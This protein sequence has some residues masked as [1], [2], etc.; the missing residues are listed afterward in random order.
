M[1]GT[2]LALVLSAALIHSGWNAL[3]KRADSQLAFLWSSV[4]VA[5]LIFL[6]LSAG[7]L[8]DGIPTEAVPY[9][10]ATIAVHAAYFYALGRALGS[11]DFSLVYPV[12]RG[13]GVGLV[14]V[15]AFLLLGEGLSPLGATGVGLVLLGIAIAH[16]AAGGFRFRR[17]SGE[18]MG[19][20]IGWAVM[21][22]LTI[23]T[24]SLVDKVGVTFLHPL[25]YL[26][27][28]GAGISLVLLPVVR[29]TA[30]LRREWTINWPTILI[31][32]CLNLTSYLL[33]LF[34]FRLS[35]AAYVVAARES[36]IVFSVLIGGIWF[37]EG[38][39]P[40]RLAV[41]GVVLAGVACVAL[42]R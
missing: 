24:Y 21:T 5:T 20:G 3:A 40:A 27:L 13:L 34:A 8:R 29:R 38:R 30:A 23:A 17:V 31:A 22:G 6:P 42:A 15:G 18:R 10:V 19:K 4:T 39:L 16:A 12:A 11:G 35:K 14:P 28:M 7:F 26:A 33:V 1:S 41:A 36:S 9:V 25:P 37:G 32:A 2:A